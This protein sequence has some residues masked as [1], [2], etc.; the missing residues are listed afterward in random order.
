V[1]KIAALFL[2]LVAIILLLWLAL[3]WDK[4]SPS[5][6]QVRSGSQNV[7]NKPAASNS[8]SN[9]N[10]PSNEVELSRPAGVDDDGWRYLKTIRRLAFSRNQPVQFYAK[11]VDQFGL[12]VEGANLKLML[13]YLDEE[14]FKS[15]NFYHKKIGDEIKNKP[16]ELISDVKGLIHFSKESG[17]VLDIQDLCKD[18]FFWQRPDGLGAIEYQ[19]DRSHI[20]SGKIV[21][22]DALDPAKGFNFH[23]WKKGKTEKLLH[24]EIG[25]TL[26]ANS[27]QAWFNVISGEV[28]YAAPA[29]A[30]F[31][32]VE[33]MLHPN[34]P[35][36][37][38]DRT[39]SIQ[40][41][42]GAKLVETADPYP[43]L[44]PE[45]GYLSEF[46]FDVLPSTG[47][48][49]RGTWDWEKNFYMVARNGKVHAGLKIG[50]VG[51]KIFFGFNGYLNP[52]GSRNLE[53]DS[54]KLIS[55]PAEVRQIDE[56]TRP[57]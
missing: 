41:L 50:F 10:S 26:S 33:T 16:I 25:V 11:I 2:S 53:P 39:M 32:I 45:S 47:N 19:P 28:N 54:Q 36:R 15:T 1:K 3:H 20:D 9:S 5:A 27:H 43:Y 14:M 42:N 13:T 34:D 52:S 29:W 44:A 55:D 7:T 8:Q 57:K 18:G 12:P 30:D 31:T 23:L 22:D 56:A 38:Y 49:Q 51:G 17:Y 48:G 40:G 37:Q 6:G 4:S 21:L 35:D 24:S 46:R